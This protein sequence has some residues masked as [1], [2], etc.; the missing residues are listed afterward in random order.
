VPRRDAGEL[1]ALPPTDPGLFAPGGAA[2]TTPTDRPDAARGA[3]HGTDTADAPAR[4]RV[5]RRAVVALLVVV[6]VAAA[7]AA[8]QGAGDRRAVRRTAVAF[9]QFQ[10]ADYV[11][12]QQTS[13]IDTEMVPDDEPAVDATLARAELVQASAYAAQERVLG[14][15]VWFDGATRRFVAAVRS[16][17][18]ARVADLH[19]LAAWRGQ[20]V[21]TRGPQPADP[22]PAA[23]AALDKALVLAAGHIV[24]PLTT[25]PPGTAA[26]QILS[27]LRLDRWTDT[28]TGSTLAVA[29]A[30]GVALVDVDA[31]TAVN[32]NLADTVLPIVGRSG[33]V[34]AV[35]ASGWVLAKTP[36][37]R[38]P[39]RMLGEAA[40]VLPATQPDA[41]WLVQ[42]AADTF[43]GAPE[44]TVTEVDGTSKRLA[45]PV[46]VPAGYY[47]TG[48]VTDEGLILSVGGARLAVWDPV[49][50]AQHLISPDPAV[51]L[52][53][54][55]HLVAWQTGRRA[56]NVTDL[57]TGATRVIAL[58]GENMIVASPDVSTTT[59]AWSPDG[60]R[61]ACPIL[62]LAPLPGGTVTASPGGA[63]PYRL[64]I[65]DIG[66]GSLTVLAGSPGRANAHP[67]VWTPDGSRVWSVVS[68]TQGSLL[69]TWSPGQ[70]TVR[71]LR[72]RVQN[73]LVGLAVVGQQP[74]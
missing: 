37:F 58:M 46:L 73:W 17:L 38:A 59:C 9:D 57:R 65:I 48:G 61:L 7:G 54:S 49:S 43:T 6:A 1:E 53:T 3:A 44:T 12:S 40:E 70:G 68:T 19:A 42:S 4:S 32:L 20:P 23:K 71:E 67:I 39:L 24:R 34:A 21:P 69:A 35:T 64:G 11:L 36:T 8:V 50:G 66:G 25:G 16:S 60:G 62:T 45:G 14:T 33:Y 18:R 41:I 56:V 30:S 5:G 27:S 72:Y 28:P 63:N 26:M 15:S 52:A 29:D 31:S 22:S 74:S 47:V 55:G 51:V 13:E 2:P 10:A